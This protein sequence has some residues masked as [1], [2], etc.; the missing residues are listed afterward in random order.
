MASVAVG[1]AGQGEQSLSCVRW[2]TQP[3][4]CSYKLI[5]SERDIWRSQQPVS[6]LQWQ[7]T[8]FHNVNEHR[9][10]TAMSFSRQCR[11]I[12]LPPENYSLK[13]TNSWTIKPANFSVYTSILA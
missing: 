7:A 5:V 12:T 11:R 4:L 9:E 13:D 1:A 8:D 2:Q 10:E 3:S 6:S